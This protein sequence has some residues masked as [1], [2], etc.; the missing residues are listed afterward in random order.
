[1]RRPWP[2]TGSRPLSAGRSRSGG[3]SELGRRRARSA[4]TK[5]VPAPRGPGRRGRCRCSS[6]WSA[7]RGRAALSAV[8]GQGGQ[9]LSQRRRHRQLPHD[10]RRRLIISERK[11]RTEPPPRPR[12]R[13]AWRVTDVACPT[14]KAGP[15]VR[16][17]SPGGHPH[18]PRVAQLRPRFP[19]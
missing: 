14:C 15:G 8:R 17:S 2:V 5:P 11:P 1:M 7:V 10:E 3:P 13:S 19:S 4:R 9:R 12:P 6:R 16:C 18:Q